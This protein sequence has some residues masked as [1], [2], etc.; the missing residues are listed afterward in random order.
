MK[1]N[2]EKERTYRE[3]F[4]GDGRIRFPIRLTTQELHYPSIANQEPFI[5]IAYVNKMMQ[6]EL[7]KSLTE[8]GRQTA[9][10][11]N[12]LNGGF[13]ILPLQVSGNY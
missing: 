1:R 10:L 4:E 6:H 9:Y 2:N 3:K 13:K 8:H 7:F 12:T 11:A 5:L